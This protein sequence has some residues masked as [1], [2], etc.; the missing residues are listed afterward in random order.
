[1][2][3][4]KCKQVG[5][6]IT[7]MKSAFEG[8]DIFLPSTYKDIS[9]SVYRSLQTFSLRKDAVEFCDN[10]GFSKTD[11]RKVESRFQAGYAIGLGRGF[12]AP[13]HA[14]AIL[15]AHGMGCVVTDIEK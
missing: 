15:V 12:F 8:R 1:M 9:A 2:A 14:Q 7:R 6:D 3:T 11:I 13:R 4:L 10:N 5:Q